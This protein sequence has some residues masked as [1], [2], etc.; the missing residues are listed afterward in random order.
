MEIGEIEF[1]PLAAGVGLL[2]GVFA[3]WIMRTVDVGIIY[4][5]GAFIFT[6]ILG[7]FVFNKIAL[8]N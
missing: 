6:S 1:N 8:Q 5:I 2:G 3:V 7:Y 4:K